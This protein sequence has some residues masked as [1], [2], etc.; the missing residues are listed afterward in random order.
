V[1]TC[2]RFALHQ[3]DRSG[4]FLSGSVRPA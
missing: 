3:G 4:T 2:A 1:D